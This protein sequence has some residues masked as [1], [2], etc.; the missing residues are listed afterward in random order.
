[1]PILYVEAVPVRVDG[2]GRVNEVGLLVRSTPTGVMTLAH[3]LL[4]ASG[5]A[6][7]FA[8]HSSDISKMISARWPSHKSQLLRCP[9]K[10]QNTFLCRASRHTTTNASTP[11]HSL[12][13]RP[14]RWELELQ[15]RCARGD[16]DASSGSPPR[17]NTERSRGWSR[18]VAPPGAELAGPLAC[19][20][21]EHHM[22]LTP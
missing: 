7:P 2:E 10:L 1:M 19:I 22:F 15:T 11:C 21:S 4:G 8:M 17:R 16:V 14:C 20:R 13:R 18:Q 5:M 12:V 6:K 9:H 3:L